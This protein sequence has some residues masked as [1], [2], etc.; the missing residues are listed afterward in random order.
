MQDTHGVP[1]SVTLQRTLRPRHR[2][3]AT[4][5]RERRADMVNAAHSDRRILRGRRVV[6]RRVVGVRSCCRGQLVGK[7][8][9]HDVKPGP[10]DRMSVWPNRRQRFQY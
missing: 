4:A 7:R 6:G 9:S 10:N 3:Q 2:S 8:L 1:V 5:E